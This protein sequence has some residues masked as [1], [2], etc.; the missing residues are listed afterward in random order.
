MINSEEIKKEKAQRLKVKFTIEE[1]KYINFRLSKD[2]SRDDLSQLR[3]YEGNF[4]F[5]K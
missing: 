4:L 2:R 3:K 1:L 5:T